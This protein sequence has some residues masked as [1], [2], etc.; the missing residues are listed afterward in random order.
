MI[1]NAWN[2]TPISNFDYVND[3]LARRTKRVDNSAVTNDFGYN[4][5][6]EVTSAAMGTNS[7]AYDFDPIGNRR[8]ASRLEAA[9]AVTNL[10]ASRAVIGNEARDCCESQG[11]VAIAGPHTMRIKGTYPRSFSGV[12]YVYMRY[13]R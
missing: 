11:E 3:S 7:Y 13:W 9:Q 8:S 12:P 4:L 5:R 2:G 10:Y 1:A 6:S